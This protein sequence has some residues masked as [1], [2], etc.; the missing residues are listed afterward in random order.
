ME[1]STTVPGIRPLMTSWRYRVRF[2]GG[3]PRG[4]QVERRTFLVFWDD[5]ATFPVA[6]DAHRFVDEL[7]RGET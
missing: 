7:C 1:T 4:W 3:W 6:D 2:C 5:L